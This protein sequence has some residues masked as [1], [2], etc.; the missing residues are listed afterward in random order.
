[1][2]TTHTLHGDL[3]GVPGNGVLNFRNIRYAASIPLTMMFGT[4]LGVVGHPD[5]WD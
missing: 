1:M 4:V 2:T 3:Q 5:D